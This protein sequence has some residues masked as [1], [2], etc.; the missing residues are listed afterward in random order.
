MIE[1]VTPKTIV[2]SHKKHPEFT[3]KLIESYA[4]DQYKKAVKD[5]LKFGKLVNVERSD[6]CLVVIDQQCYKEWA[7]LEGSQYMIDSRNDARF[8]KKK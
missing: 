7:D 3:E 8:N 5:L 6:V 1:K 4:F 2:E